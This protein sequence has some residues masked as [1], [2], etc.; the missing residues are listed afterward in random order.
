M[1]LT[2]VPPSVRTR[3][4]E[5]D[6][7]Q[8]TVVGHRGPALLVRGAAGTGKTTAALELVAQR[9]VRGELRADEVLVL[10]PTRRAA[11]RLRDDLS[12][13][14]GRT[15]G[16]PVVRTAASAAFSVL[17]ARA[18]LLGEPPPTLISGPEQD[19]VLAELLAGH[20]AGEGARVAW[21][22]RVPAGALGLRAFRDELRDLLMRAAERGLRPPELAHLGQQH[23]R[24]EWVAAAAVYAEYLDV[25]RLRSGT[26]D[27]GARYDAAV[28]VDEA[29]E[30]LR[31][32]DAEVPGAPRPGWRLVVVDDHQES[33]AATARLLHVLADAGADVVLLAD[34]DA[35][36]QTFRGASPGL[37][38]RAGAPRGSGLGAFGATEVVLGTVWRHG[39]VVR[40]VVRAVT[41]EI[42]GPGRRHRAA[43]ASA[44]HAPSGEPREHGL[45]GGAPVAVR[46]LRSPAQEAAYV[47]HT[48]RSAHLH[49]GVPW[50]RMA[51]VVRSGGQVAELRRALLAAQVPVAVVGSDVALRAEPAVRPLLLAL[52]AVLGAEALEP[53][54]AAE[55]LTSPLGGLDAVGLRRVRRALRAEELSADGERT[56]DV[57]LVEALAAPE[58]SATLPTAVR[59]PVQRLAAVLRAGREA[60]AAPGSTVLDV[61]WALWSAS[62]L[63]EPWRRRAVAGGTGGA[64]ADRDLDAVLALFTAAEQFVDRL[65]MAP[66]AA[67]VE[68]L[69]A[70]DLPADS[71]AARGDVE[72]SVPVLTAA[73]AAGG[74]WDVCVVA[75]VQ[76]GVWPDLRVRD[77]LLGAQHLVEVLAGR[78][79]GGPGATAVTAEARAAVLDDEL[80]A[81]AVAV[82]RARRR[83][84]VTAV[85]DTDHQPSSLLDL[86]DAGPGEE[87]ED[88]RLVQVPPALDLRAVVARCRGVLE[89]APDAGP[90]HPAAVLLARLA[91]DGVPGADP[92]HWYGVAEPST[93]APLWPA[94]GTVPLSPSKLE[95][96]ATCAL[97]WALE[98]AGGTAA[99]SGEQSLGTLVHAVAAALPSGDEAE[100]AALLDERWGELGLG[101]GWVGSV[102]RRRADGMIRHL[103][104]YLRGAGQVVAVEEPFAVQVG[105]VLLRGTVDRLERLPDA[106]DGS[107]RVRV[108]DL[109]TGRSP[110]SADA[111]SRHAQLGAYQEAL[112]AGAFTEH[113]GGATSG[114]AALVYV[115]TTNK[116]PSV[117]EQVAV[118]EDPEPEWARRLLD[119]VATTVSAS[120]VSATANDLCRT[121]PVRRSCPVQPEGRVVGA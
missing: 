107:P 49:D 19:M 20:A 79:V 14:L 110:V 29:A 90:S 53:A 40:G 34:P 68:H 85:Q 102:Q 30:A 71:L 74:E 83:L 39:P 24:P 22:P 41:E 2:L 65:P 100:L 91:A 101:D 42:R 92:R 88:T 58:H 121:C 4:P 47:A 57:L 73:A 97:R 113:T 17:R 105:R 80:R 72:E 70:Q 87:G 76:E 12:V 15:T 21:P 13:R 82:S 119:D 66:P 43:E 11:A 56:S 32:W 67:F 46:F 16:Q 3:W 31:A 104:A 1:T 48:L 103:A 115:G 50:S 10:A 106:P 60:A 84:V 69:A 45:F 25:T 117:R 75:G 51:V 8:R 55:L 111:V 54:V 89:A 108:V 5:P 61:L 44:E 37:V 116:K 36:V 93:S 112:E 77:S 118:A 114:G 18:S 96:A 52:G 7:D 6:A 98:A 33:T 35:A 26:P 86:V 63:D 38:D 62:G 27:A 94:D 23:A 120:A 109:K 9:V 59:R 95:A 78:A 64:R 28:V 99:D 81:F